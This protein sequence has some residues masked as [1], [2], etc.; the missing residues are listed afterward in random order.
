MGDM[1]DLIATLVGVVVLVLGSF[2]VGTRSGRQSEKMDQASRQA[3]SDAKATVKAKEAQDEVDRM[4]DP[5]ILDRLR[6][7][8]GK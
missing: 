1:T 4:S 7:R 3:K 5:D 2:F 6:Q 8:S